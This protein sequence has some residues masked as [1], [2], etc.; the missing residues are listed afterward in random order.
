MSS[1]AKKKKKFRAE[2]G[3]V[4]QSKQKL[5]SIH[6]CCGNCK[7]NLDIFSRD[8]VKCNNKDSRL[9]RAIMPKNEY[10]TEYK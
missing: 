1:R 6:N 3:I 4:R 8:S 7:S 10:C 2:H 5:G 9:F